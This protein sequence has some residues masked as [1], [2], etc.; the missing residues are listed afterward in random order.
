MTLR[1]HLSRRK[2]RV[3]FVFFLGFAVFGL[4]LVVGHGPV[5]TIAVALVGF[6]ISMGAV[7]FMLFG[8]RCPKCQE[9]IGYQVS[10]PGGPFSVSH[11][12]KFC[13]Y[14]GVALDSDV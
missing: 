11:R 3:N 7:L 2:R 9:P 8:V 4:S 6:A 5:L 14:C 1:E 10:Y 13:A 12:I